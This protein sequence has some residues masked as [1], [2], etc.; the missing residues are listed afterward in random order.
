MGKCIYVFPSLHSPLP[1]LELWAQNNT[2]RIN[3]NPSQQ[4]HW[5]DVKRHHRE[6]RRHWPMP[7]F[8]NRMP[9]RCP[10]LPYQG[11]SAVLLLPLCNAPRMPRRGHP[12]PHPRPPP[13]TEGQHRNTGNGS[14]SPFPFG[15]RCVQNGKGPPEA[16]RHWPPKVGGNLSGFLY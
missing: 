14:S 11:H 12:F 9:R 10:A 16:G 13:T 5:T 6:L 2:L 8:L 1:F 3:K 4:N 7:Q 15:Q